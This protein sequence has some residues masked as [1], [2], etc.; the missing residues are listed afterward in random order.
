MAYVS[1]TAND[2]AALRMAIIAACTANGWTL[3][4][5][6]IHKGGVF[7][8]LTTSSTR[9]LSRAGTGIDGSNTLTNAAPGDASI[10]SLTSGFAALTWPLSYEVFIHANPDEVYVV[11]N[12]SGVYYQWLAFG[13]SPVTLPGSGVW[14][15]GSLDGRT[16]ANGVL[17]GS[18]MNATSDHGWRAEDGYGSGPCPGLFW[19]NGG[20]TAKAGEYIQHGLD[21]QS[22][23]SFSNF[24]GAPMAAP[25]IYIQP[26]G[27]NSEAVLIPIQVWA[28]RPESKKS[29]V[30]DCENARYI[31]VD[32][33]SPGE[34]IQLGADRWKVFPWFRK[35]VSSR[36]GNSSSSG[37]YGW[38]IRYD[39]P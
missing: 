26:S 3:G 13:R 7:I 2:L 16:Y 30:L 39:G 25:L 33:H 38:A 11:L 18:G 22:E 34:V 5:N 36:N 14:V 21:T 12:Y 9:L 4:G 20:G 27:W 35:D 17:M 8:Q 32:N 23:W 37:T 10:G 28:S 31:R 19:A 15:S 6:V 29:I 24:N 1:G